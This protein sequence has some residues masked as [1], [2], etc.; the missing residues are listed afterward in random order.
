MKGSLVWSVTNFIHERARRLTILQNFEMN[1]KLDKVQ[2]LL[3]A[4]AGNFSKIGGKQFI[5]ERFVDS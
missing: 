2:S 3:S 5:K 4:I 1:A